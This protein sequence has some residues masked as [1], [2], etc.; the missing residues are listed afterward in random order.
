MRSQE[1][2]WWR[3]SWDLSFNEKFMAFLW[4]ISRRFCEGKI[5]KANTFEDL[6]KIFTL[7]DHKKIFSCFLH[8]SFSSQNLREIF[9]RKSINFSSI[10]KSHEDP[11]QRSS[12]D[13]IFRKIFNEDQ[14]Q[15]FRKD[16]VIFLLNILPFGGWVAI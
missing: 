14:L 2:L 12:W 11:H 5:F 8:L 10:L 7:K 13:L 15:N 3:S 16:L 6:V 4:Q 9:P 1:D